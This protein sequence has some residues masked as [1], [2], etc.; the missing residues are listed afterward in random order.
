VLPIKIAGIAMVLVSFFFSAWIG[1]VLNALDI[2]VEPR[3]TLLAHLRFDQCRRGRSA[4]GDPRLPPSVIELT[5]VVTSLLDGVS[6]HTHASLLEDTAALLYWIFLALSSG[7]LSVCPAP[8]GN[9]RSTL[10]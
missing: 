9:S 7:S 1:M 3:S 10:P 6:G 2:A 4:A 8:R 5:V